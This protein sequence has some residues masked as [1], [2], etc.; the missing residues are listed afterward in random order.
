MTPAGSQRTGVDAVDVAVRRLG[1]LAD[2]PVAEHVDVLDD[3]HR[4]LQGALA[5]LDEG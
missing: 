4:R 5:D 1:E 3:V 2:R